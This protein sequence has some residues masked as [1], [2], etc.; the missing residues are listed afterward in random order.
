LQI[1]DEKPTFQY[2]SWGEVNKNGS[3]LFRFVR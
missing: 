3:L 2:L 1:G